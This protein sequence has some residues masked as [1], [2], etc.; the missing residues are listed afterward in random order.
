VG[1]HVGQPAHPVEIL[2]GAEQLERRDRGAQQ[3]EVD[4]AGLQVGDH[5]P[6]GPA[7]LEVA[8]VDAIPG[9]AVDQLPR[10]GNCGGDRRVVRGP[11]VLQYSNEGIGLGEERLGGRPGAAV[12]LDALVPSALGFVPQVFHEK[13]QPAPGQGEM[14]RVLV[15]DVA[16]GER[17]QEPG[18]HCR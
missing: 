18:L 17:V 11:E 7:A 5:L 14:P 4:A 2:K 15:E 8:A 3:I 9:A 10:P 1:G 12:A 6:P 13:A 16:S